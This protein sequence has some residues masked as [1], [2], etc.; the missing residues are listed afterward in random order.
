MDLLF[1]VYNFDCKSTKKRANGKENVSEFADLLFFSYL[2]K[3]NFNISKNKNYE[4][5]WK[6]REL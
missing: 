2:C 5:K 6:K 4:I 1:A 3:Q